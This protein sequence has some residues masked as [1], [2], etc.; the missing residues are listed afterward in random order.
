MDLCCEQKDKR[1]V[2]STILFHF[3]YKLDDILI[4]G[5]KGKCELPKGMEYYYKMQLFIKDRSATTDSNLYIVF[6]CTM[7]G[8]GE[9][10]FGTKL[11][12]EVPTDQT[13]KELKRLYKTLTR[14]WTAI[15]F[16]V[17]AVEVASKQPVFFLV[18]TALTI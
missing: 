1:T 7:E 16:M 18:D 9:E 12:T 3:R 5:K 13:L 6:L 10:F 8:K 15:D 4:K 2:L 17:E 11:G 14:P